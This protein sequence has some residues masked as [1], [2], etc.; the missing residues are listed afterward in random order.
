MVQL[1]EIPSND[2]IIKEIEVENDEDYEDIEDEEEEVPANPTEVNGSNEPS[3]KAGVAADIDGID[4]EDDDDEDDDDDDMDESLI[5]RLSALTEIIPY[6]T[7]RSVYNAVSGTLGLGYGVLRLA[8]GLGWIVATASLLV[9]LPVA[10]EVE[11]ETFALMAEAQQRGGA[12]GQAQQ[13]Q[14]V[15]G[16]P[17]A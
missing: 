9:A 14:Q 4:D 13:A 16:G 12:H 6:A 7:R 11:R 2:P 10:L 5:E 8:G 3:T 15:I 1:T 17:A